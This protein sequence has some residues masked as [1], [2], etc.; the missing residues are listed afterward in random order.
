MAVGDRMFL[1]MQDF[2]FA[3]IYSYVPKSNH[4]CPNFFLISP[5]FIQIWPNVTNL[6][7]KSFATRCGYTIPVSSAP[8][9]WVE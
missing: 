1:G 4:F 3:Q 9:S 6:A 2:D 7:Q 5:K 8:T